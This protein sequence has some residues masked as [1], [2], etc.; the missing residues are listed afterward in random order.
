MSTM[1]L[2]FAAISAV[3]QNT[4]F[5]ISGLSISERM[6]TIRRVCFQLITLTLAFRQQ[7]IDQDELLTLLRDSRTQGLTREQLLDVAV[8]L[9]SNVERNESLLRDAESINF[10]LWRDSLNKIAAQVEQFDSFAESFRISADTEMQAHLASLV[11]GAPDLSDAT[12][13]R[14]F[15]ATLQD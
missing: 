3:E 15:V 9:E 14:D 13:W 10:P 12:N 1:V 5:V 6:H 8:R 2:P 11:D 7:V 4:T